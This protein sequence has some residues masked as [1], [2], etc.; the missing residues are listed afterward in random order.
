MTWS[1][2]NNLRGELQ[3]WNRQFW[4]TDC[5]SYME[6]VKSPSACCKAWFLLAISVPLLTPIMVVMWF[7]ICV[8]AARYMMLPF[9]FSYFFYFL[10]VLHM[11]SPLVFELQVTGLRLN[12]ALKKPSPC[13][14]LHANLDGFMIWCQPKARF[15]V[16]EGCMFTLV[17]AKA[18]G[19]YTNIWH[20]LHKGK[21][22]M[23]FGSLYF[24]RAPS[25]FSVFS[26]RSA[27][28]THLLWELLLLLKRK[29]IVVSEKSYRFDC[30]AI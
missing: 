23:Y 16:F 12:P 6:R 10:F 21:Q 18:S 7:G 2:M 22:Q 28:V 29:S 25:V 17:L 20:W 1:V 4:H 24:I 3:D 30:V 11:Q 8:G 9:F 15:A 14:K 26:R 5:D 13:A 27:L 19:H